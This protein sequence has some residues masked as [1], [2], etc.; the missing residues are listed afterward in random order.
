MIEKVYVLRFDTE[1][2][3]TYIYGVYSTRENAML[4]LDSMRVEFGD[5]IH[6]EIEAFE[7]DYYY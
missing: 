1:D 4:G 3:E 2:G 5:N 7:I 6:Y